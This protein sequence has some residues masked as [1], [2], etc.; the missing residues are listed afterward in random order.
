MMKNKMKKEVIIV[1]LPN[2][3]DHEIYNTIRIMINI[4]SGSKVFSSLVEKTELDEDDSDSWFYR[5][6]GAWEMLNVTDQAQGKHKFFVEILNSTTKTL[7]LDPEHWSALYLRSFLRFM[8]CGDNI[9]EMASYLF[10]NYSIEDAKTD[11]IRMIE[12]Q[13]NEEK[14]PYFFIPYI[15]LALYY[16]EKNNYD[17]AVTWIERG[18]EE[19][20][21]DKLKYLGFLFQIPVFMLYEKLKSCGKMETAKKITDRYTVMF[22]SKKNDRMKG[23]VY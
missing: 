12:L 3:E 6:L 21:A 5:A 17:K 2:S 22:D 8:M 14:K 10:N 20:S 7:S 9:E 4:N 18:L 16:I 19:T 11:T 1:R 13:K 15:E 23:G